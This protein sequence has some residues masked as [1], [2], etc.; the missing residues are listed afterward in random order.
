MGKPLAASLLA[1][2]LAVGT[3]SITARADCNPR[4]FMVQEVTSIQQSLETELAFILTANQKEYENAQKNAAGT[5]PYGLFSLSYG[6]AQTKAREIAQSIKFDYRQSYASNYFNQSLSGKALDAYVK[7]L[8]LDKEKPGLALW[9]QKREGDYFTFG[10]FWV[11]ADTKQ[12]AARYDAQPVLDGAKLISSPIRF[13][14][15]VPS[16]L[17]PIHFSTVSMPWPVV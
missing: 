13:V 17:P 1:T 8:E 2:L 4:D 3:T 7:R 16:L 5:D 15:P 6:D 9:L 14:G 12:P 11:G 10:A